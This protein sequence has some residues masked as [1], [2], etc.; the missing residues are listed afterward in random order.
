[1]LGGFSRCDTF[2]ASHT[3]Q[4][5]GAAV[6]GTHCR[7]LSEPTQ[8]VSNC[9]AFVIHFLSLSLCQLLV[10]MLVRRDNYATER[11][12]ATAPDGKKVPVSL[13][14]RKNLVRRDGTDPFLLDAYGAAQGFR[15]F[16]PAPFCDSLLPGQ[17]P[18]GTMCEGDDWGDGR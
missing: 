15:T 3:K 1:V 17:A 7:P 18:E 16:A 10:M 5:S 6:G 12:W 13:V 2:L 11:L 14:Y 8:S 4:A 9:T